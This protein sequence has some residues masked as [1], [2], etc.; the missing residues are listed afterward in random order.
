MIQPSVLQ[1]RPFPSEDSALREF[2]SK[3]RS[4]TGAAWEDRANIEHK[5]CVH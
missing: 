4:K 2:K 5:V 1:Y 3:F